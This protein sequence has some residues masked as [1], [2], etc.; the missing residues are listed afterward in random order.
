MGGRTSKKSAL[1]RALIFLSTIRLSQ[2]VEIPVV[3]QAVVYLLVVVSLIQSLE[4]PEEAIAI[5]LN[6]TSP[7]I[8][9]GVQGGRLV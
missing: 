6:R 9:S 4:I 2:L 7:A 5:L 3:N 1:N 8:L